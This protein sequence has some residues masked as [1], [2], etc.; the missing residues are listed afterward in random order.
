MEERDAEQIKKLELDIKVAFKEERFEDVKKLAEK[1]SSLDPENH[2]AER[3]LEKTKT[4]EADQ[5]KAVNAGKI[6]ELEA[7]SVIIEKF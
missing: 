4:A 2:L 7:I 5:L 1:I 6:K 3:L